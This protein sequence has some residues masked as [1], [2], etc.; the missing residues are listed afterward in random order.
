[1]AEPRTTSPATV[2]L[3]GCHGHK[4]GNCAADVRNCV[5]VYVVHISSGCGYIAAVSELGSVPAEGPW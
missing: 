2:H 3:L 5:T 1:M 4:R